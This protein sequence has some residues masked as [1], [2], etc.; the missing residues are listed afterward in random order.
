MTWRRTGN[1]GEKWGGQKREVE[2]RGNKGRKEGR[3]GKTKDGP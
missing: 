3:K 1:R 2:D